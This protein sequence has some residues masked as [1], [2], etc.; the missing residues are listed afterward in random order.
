MNRYDDIYNRVIQFLV[1]H[2]DITSKIIDI[3]Y[4]DDNLHLSDILYDRYTTS[5]IREIFMGVASEVLSDNRE[6]QDITHPDVLIG[7]C[8]YHNII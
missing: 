2:Y 7:Y 6:A 1:S 4:A 8:L 3:D 5:E